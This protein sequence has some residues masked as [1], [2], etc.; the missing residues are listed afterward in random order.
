MECTGFTTAEA[1]RFTEV[2]AIPGAVDAVHSLPSDRWAVVT[3]ALHDPALE[4]LTQVGI[5][6]PSVLIGADDVKRGKPHPEGYRAAAVGLGAGA[7]GL[8]GVRGHHGRG[9]RQG[10]ARD[11][12][13]IA[14]GDLAE[15]A[16]FAGRID[17]FRSVRFS[18]AGDDELFLDFGDD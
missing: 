2:T 13:S 3:S 6:E 9:S 16:G 7:A 4:R 17:D 14:V 1:E 8:R 10:S 11:A 15:C 12:W 5:P 18:E